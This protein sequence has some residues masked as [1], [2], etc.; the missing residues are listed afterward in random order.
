MQADRRTQMGITDQYR[1]ML[2]IT[3]PSYVCALCFPGFWYT[4][5]IEQSLPLSSFLASIT[6]VPPKMVSPVFLT[7]RQQP[8]AVVGSANEPF[9]ARV[10]FEWVGGGK[11]EV[12]HWI[13]VCQY[14]I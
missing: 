8:F 1:W 2:G 14:H 7:A 3:S 9:M 11:M 5:L 4:E 13:E 6:V 10:I 12:E